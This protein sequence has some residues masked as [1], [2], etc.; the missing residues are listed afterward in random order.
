MNLDEKINHETSKNIKEYL[1]NKC[2]KKYKCNLVS[3]VIIEGNKIYVYHFR[4]ID[5]K[6]IKIE[7]NCD[8]SLKK[9]LMI[10]YYN[11]KY[12][13]NDCNIDLKLNY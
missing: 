7:E 6:I 1:N 11:L 3:E 8:I 5:L 12:L 10:L 4:M 2:Y 13:E 9:L